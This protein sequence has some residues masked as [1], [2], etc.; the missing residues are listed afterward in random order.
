M[1]YRFNAFIS[2]RRVD[3]SHAAAWLRRRLRGFRLPVP[4]QTNDRRRQPLKIYLD[5][6]YERAEEDFFENTIKPALRESEHLIVVQTPGARQRRSDGSRNWVE[7]EI[8]YFRS[9]DQG[10]NISV[11]LASGEFQDPLPEGLDVD[12][13]NIDRVDIR[14]KRGWSWLRGDDHILPFIAKLQ[15]LQFDEMPLLRQE[16]AR[17]RVRQLVW[18]LGAVSIVAIALSALT[19][20]A[21]VSRSAANTASL[22]AQRRERQSA[23]SEAL[24]RASQNFGEYQRVQGR[25]QSSDPEG[26]EAKSLSALAPKYQ[27]Q[28]RSHQAR[29]AELDAKFQDWLKENDIAASTPDTALSIEMLRAHDGGSLIMHYGPPSA[30]GLMIIDGGDRRTYRESIRPRLEQLRT[31]RGTPLNI[32]LVVSSQTDAQYLHG[33]IEMLNEIA[34]TIPEQRLVRIERLWSNAFLPPGDLTPEV[35]ME[36]QPKSRLLLQARA[37]G[38]PLNTPFSRHVTLPQAGSARVSSKHGLAITVLGPP[39]PSLE[40]FARGWIKDWGRRAEWR[41][42][43]TPI[44]ELPDDFLLE[45][46]ADPALEL[47]PSPIDIAR[48]EPPEGTSYRERS[49]VNLGSL[50]LMVEIAGRRILLPSDSRGD[51]L[52]GALAQAGYIDVT[53]T[54]DVDVMVVPHGGSDQNVSVDF[55]RRVRARHYVFLADGTHNNPEVRT[56]QMLFEGRRNDANAFMIHLTYRPEEYRPGYPLAALCEEF[57]KRRDAGVSFKVV[58][59]AEHSPS[60]AIQL[61]REIPDLPKG[62]EGDAC[63]PPLSAAI[64]SGR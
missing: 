55:F 38:I 31:Q 56:F 21:L 6:I 36:I 32:D 17:R 61:L 3:G 50:V 18:V 52:V 51:F 8:E 13:E 27:Q 46:F 37:L 47:I 64:K 15:D 20:W 62:V 29:A 25:I 9:L 35:L 41:S 11:A 12:F 22:E 45:S 30:P 40:R 63:T 58:T 54:T 44:P 4:L 7:R 42:D 2:Y 48:A 19:A 33:L 26:F 23:I 34:E 28:A 39:L 43:A 24:A 14:H 10:R 53:G 49:F 60:A 1:G 16:D 5:T 57:R 59:P